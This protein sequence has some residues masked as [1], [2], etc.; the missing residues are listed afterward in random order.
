M[1][2]LAMWY[3]S[4]ALVLLVLLASCAQAPESAQEIVVLADGD[5]LRKDAAEYAKD[6]QVSLDEAV[7]RL[8]LQDDIG[9]FEK[10]LAA[11]EPDTFGGL[12]IQH[13][14]AYKVIVNM[15]SGTEKIASYA[16]DTAFAREIEVHKVA[17]SLKQLETHQR[18]IVNTLE[19][20]KLKSESSTNVYTNQV[21]LD[22]LN[23]DQLTAGLRTLGKL[24]ILEGVLATRVE[25]FASPEVNIYGGNNMYCTSGF[26]VRDGN[27]TYGITTADHCPS[28]LS[29]GSVRLETLARWNGSSD[30]QWQRHTS[31]THLYKPWARDNEPT[32]GGTNYYREIYG[33]A[34]RSDQPI[35]ALVCKYGITTRYTCGYLNSKTVTPSDERYSQPTYMRYGDGTRDMSDGG[36][37]GG[38]TYVG[39]QAWGMHHGGYN[40]GSHV[41]N[42]LYMAANYI[43]SKGL[44]INLAP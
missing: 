35:G 44:I 18:L 12:W 5:A 20:L 4:I 19:A 2:L 9:K 15:T 26:S 27:G 17:T 41:G 36:D 28:D 29:Y 3:A 10:K 40:S 22:V 6:Q 25:S 38:P 23:L 1:K 34:N 11:N 24:S 7:R 8:E 32:S 30:L 31:G 42:A 43:A 33:S 13:K 39:H 14:P 21:E 37:S 16:Q